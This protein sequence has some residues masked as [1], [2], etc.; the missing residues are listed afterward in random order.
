MSNR[1]FASFDSSRN[2]PQTEYMS[3]PATLKLSEVETQLRR[4]EYRLMI[5]SLIQGQ[6]RPYLNRMERMQYQDICQQLDTACH[7]PGC[8]RTPED[9]E[10]IEQFLNRFR[11]ALSSLDKEPCDLDAQNDL[12]ET[13][14][15]LIPLIRQEV[16]VHAS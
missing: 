11:T 16:L 1:R 8:K 7:E 15:Q 12:Q 5:L 14:K 4:L 3:V 2:T 10:Q 13:G 9:V 6:G